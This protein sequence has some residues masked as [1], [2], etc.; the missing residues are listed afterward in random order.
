MNPEL[1][2]KSTT[3]TPV[4][5]AGGTQLPTVGSDAYV[6]AQAGVLPTGSYTASTIP[7]STLNT[8]ERSYTLPTVTSNNTGLVSQIGSSVSSYAQGIAKQQ[9][10]EQKRAQEVANKT[11]EQN[12][13]RTAGLDILQK[14]GLRGQ[15]QVTQEA[16]LGIPQKRQ[17]VSKL[18]SD[19]EALDLAERRQIE[20]IQKTP[21]LSID[22]INTQTQ[23]ISR[24]F[25]REKADKGILLSAL[26]RDLATTQDYVDKKI[27]LETADLKNTWESIKF[28]YDENKDYLSKEDDRVFQRAEKDAERTYQEAL[29]QK[30]KLRDVALDTYKYLN[31]NQA[32]DEIYAAVSS[33]L[34]KS[35]ATPLDVIRAAGKYGFDYT[36]QEYKRAQTNKLNAEANSARSSLPAS[37]QVK[38]QTIAGQFDNEQ[39]VK[40]YQT[41]AEAI[42]AIK[43][44]GVTPTDD[45]SRIYAFAKVMDPNS[46]VREGEY[47]TVQDY[48]T[49][50]LERV[51]L[52]AKRVFDN[53]GFLTTE[54]RNF[55][56]KT[57]ENRL[58]SSRKA[59][60]NIYSEYG[61]RIDKVTGQTDGK[62]Y[63]TDYARAFDTP[64]PKTLQEYVVQFPDKL[65]MAKQ[66]LRDN[67]SL[68]DDDVIQILTQ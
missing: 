24:Q 6:Q 17:D 37:T 7:L 63:I 22:Q 30:N 32:P 9:I 45:I 27:Q 5:F 44:A 23:D 46:V 51:G 1:L 26:S 36:E 67:P 54:A 66:I 59:Y 56:L 48:S 38:V 12:K 2:N 31:L 34:S 8:Q 41:S 52:K 16:N 35:D 50:V 11:D 25:A 3:A 61:R 4:S 53:Q 15:A 14:L 28:F 60:D 47:K 33:V 57:L 55:M 10:D 19:I 13:L 49:A 58:A 20:K 64:K 62:D 21:G 29:S 68:S 42:D 18:T 39:A 65:D 40:N 43:N